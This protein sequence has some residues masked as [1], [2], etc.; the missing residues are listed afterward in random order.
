MSLRY[1]WFDTETGGL[2]PQQHSLLT[3]YF[4]V[5]DENHNII[6]DLNLQMKPEDESK[7]SVTEGAMNV[8]KINLREHLNDPNTITYSEANRKLRTLLEKNKIKGKRKHFIP[9]GHN[10]AFDKDFIWSQLIPKEQF[11]ETVHYRTL[12]TSSICTFLKDIEILPPDVGSLTSLVEF[13]DI[14]M[15]E[16]HNARGDILMNIEVYKNIKNLVNSR[17]TQMIGDSNNSLL[18]IIEE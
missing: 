18:Q 2:D 5:C 13:F 10:V 11:E 12:D 17:K 9:C 14:P 15:G 6:D 16:A 4:A 7:I 8:N 1:L 3:A